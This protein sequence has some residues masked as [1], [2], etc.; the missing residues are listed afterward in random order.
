MTPK[1]TLIGS[2]LNQNFHVQTLLGMSVL[3]GAMNGDGAAMAG[4]LSG[5]HDRAVRCFLWFKETG[6][7]AS[8]D[9]DLD[10][11]TV[12]KGLT[13]L[14]DF[15]RARVQGA[16]DAALAQDAASMPLDRSRSE[17]RP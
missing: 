5:Q 4:F 13:R 11:E 12:E 16:I 8:C 2:I 15:V 1:D 9:G 17:V 6:S 3:G 14:K 10:N 7:Q